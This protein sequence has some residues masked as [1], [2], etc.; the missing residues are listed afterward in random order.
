MSH[1]EQFKQRKRPALPVEA[2]SRLA[3]VL[4]GLLRQVKRDLDRVP[5]HPEEAIHALRRRMKKLQ[6][7]I[8]LIDGLADR[9]TKDEMK[10]LMLEIK[11]AFADQRDRAVMASLALKIGGRPLAHQFP[12]KQGVTESWV[13]AGCH[14]AAAALEGIVAV[15]PISSLTWT[16]IHEVHERTMQK[17]RR[18]WRNAQGKPTAKHLHECRKLTKALYYQFLFIRLIKGRRKRTIHH[19]RRLGHWLGRHHDLHVFLKTLQDRHLLGGA[20]LSDMEKQEKKLRK[21]AFQVGRKFYGKG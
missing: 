13:M 10:R 6:S 3:W 19:A 2:G 11:N 8:L 5:E 18:L 20:R 1:R 21:R 12:R 15:L 16:D 4:A 7:L 14:A 9:E 17:A